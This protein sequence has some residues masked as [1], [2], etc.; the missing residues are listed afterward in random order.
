VFQ[1]FTISPYYLLF[2]AHSLLKVTQK[3][4]YLNTL[5]RKHQHMLAKY[6]DNMKKIKHCI[7]CNSNLIKKLIDCSSG[8]FTNESAALKNHNHSAT[9]TTKISSEDIDKVQ[10]T[11]KQFARDWSSDGENKLLYF[12]EHLDNKLFCFR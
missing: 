4:V 6:S 10:I 1:H 7:E 12:T 9:D 8:L 2:R 11:L 3:E 5:P